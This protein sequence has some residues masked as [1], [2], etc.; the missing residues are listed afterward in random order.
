MKIISYDGYLE[1]SLYIHFTIEGG[2]SS[3]SIGDVV[4]CSETEL[5]IDDGIAYDEELQQ[6]FKDALTEYGARGLFTP[7]M[8]FI[9]R[10]VR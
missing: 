2:S 1:N 9:H 7:I 3:L 8:G 5:E 6:E 4:W 10:I